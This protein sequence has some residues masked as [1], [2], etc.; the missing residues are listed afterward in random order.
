[1]GH[2]KDGDKERVLPEYSFD[3]CSPGDELGFKWI[4]LA[5]KERGTRSFMATAVPTKG[6]WVILVG[7]NVWIPLK[8]MGIKKGILF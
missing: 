4:V 2:F 7:I 5:G 1:M 6:G 3:Y 8:K